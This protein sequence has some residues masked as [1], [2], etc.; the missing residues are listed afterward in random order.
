MRVLVAGWFSIEDGGATAGDMLVRDVLCDWLREHNVPHDIAQERRHG[1]GVDWFRVSPERYTHL[2][3]AC[4]PVGPHLAVRELIDRFAVCRRAAINVSLV[5]DP[6]WRPFDLLIER[7]GAE[8]PRPDLALAA[9]PSECPPV[10]AL[11]KT[12]RQAEYAGA[13]LDDAHS[14]FDR[15]L[16][17]REAAVFA[18]DT[19]LDPQIPGRR[20]AAEVKAILAKADV[21]LTTRLHGLVLALAQGVPALAVDPIPGGAKVLAQAQALAWPAALT[22]DAIDDVAL[23]QHLTWCL[24]VEG[25]QRARVCADA[26]IER[27]EEIHAALAA[28][29]RRSGDSHAPADR[30]AQTFT[31][32][33]LAGRTV[34]PT[35]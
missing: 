18:V 8:A 11:V 13:R 4:G 20:T 9:G 3:F 2:V 31:N 32:P 27:V 12:H 22:V 14:A 5:G 34:M 35:E 30:S 25:R 28:Y 24:T 33:M 1:P 19:V 29:V 21:V 6:A 16:A 26:G 7:D 10:L 23:E 17:S 15:L